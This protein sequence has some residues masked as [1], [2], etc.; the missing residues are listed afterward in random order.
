MSWHEARETTQDDAFR[1]TAVDKETLSLNFK[2]CK[3]FLWVCFL[4]SRWLSAQKEPG[5]NLRILA[6]RTRSHEIFIMTWLLLSDT[7]TTV[8]CMYCVSACIH[9]MYQFYAFGPWLWCHQTGTTWG[10][11]LLSAWEWSSCPSTAVP[12]QWGKTTSSTKAFL[13]LQF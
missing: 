7:C 1:A 9:L 5:W 6:V 2:S 12:H 3:T 8:T 13:K 4:A 10:G 11:L